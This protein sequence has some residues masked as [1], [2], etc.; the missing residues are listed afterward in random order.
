[1]LQIRHLTMT[2]TKDL[3]TLAEDFSFVLN[4]GDKAAV[5]GEEGNG[6]STMLKWIYDPELIELYATMAQ[7]EIEK[8][9]KQEMVNSAKPKKDFLKQSRKVNWKK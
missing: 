3:R 5:I 7:A 8:K 4:P 9:E 6:K 1:M 2:H